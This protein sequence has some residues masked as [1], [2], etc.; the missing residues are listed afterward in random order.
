[1]N[2][3]GAIKNAVTTLI[4]ITLTATNCLFAVKAAKKNAIRAAVKNALLLQK[5]EKSL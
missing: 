3:C 2:A 4:A 5:G 1:M